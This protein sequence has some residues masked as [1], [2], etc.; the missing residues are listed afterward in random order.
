MR[1][2][3][4]STAVVLVA[5]LGWCPAS[6]AQ[7][8][9]LRKVLTI[10]SGSQFFPPNPVVDSAIRDVLITRSDIPIDYFTE[11]IETDRFGPL[12][13]SALAEYIRRKYE[14]HHIDVVIAI[15]NYAFQFVL[16]HRDLFPDAP[17]AFAGIAA[18]D[19]SVRS[20]GRGIAV[21]R[22]GSAYAETL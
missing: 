5:M 22:G 3:L 8:Q 1:R 11:Y 18:P 4:V 7:E 17:I 12:A 21:V 6:M 10:H 14:R 15:T 9:P 13:S 16:D 19:Q 2:V 20:A